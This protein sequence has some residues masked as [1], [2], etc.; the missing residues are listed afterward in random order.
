MSPC[1]ILS[2]ALIL[3]VAPRGAGPAEVGPTGCSFRQMKSIRVPRP[4]PRMYL[5]NQSHGW[6]PTRGAT[7][8]LTIDFPP[9]SIAKVTMSYGWTPAELRVSGEDTVRF[10]AARGI[11]LE[12]PSSD[13]DWIAHPAYRTVVKKERESLRVMGDSLWAMLSQHGSCAP[14]TFVENALSFVQRIIA[15]SLVHPTL[16]GRYIASWLPPLMTVHHESGDCD[17]KVFLLTGLWDTRFY[18]DTMVVF[19]YPVNDTTLHMVAFVPLPIGSDEVG[20]PGG[21][22]NECRVNELRDQYGVKYNVCDVQGRCPMGFIIDEKNRT[23][24]EDALRPDGCRRQR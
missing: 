11:L 18:P 4:Y 10:A 16:N 8:T 23:C 24:L 17:S 13:A 19:E 9:E 22:G 12:K 7:D 5:W 6:L 21:I 2:I 20:H 1:R 15:D 3:L 14:R